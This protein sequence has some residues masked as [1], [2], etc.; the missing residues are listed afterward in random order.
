MGADC[1]SV[2]LCLRRF[3]SFICHS[4]NVKVKTPTSR[5]GSCAF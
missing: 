2:D 1:K 5:W 4:K 3:E